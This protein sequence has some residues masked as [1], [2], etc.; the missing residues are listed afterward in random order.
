MQ[1]MFEK[2]LKSYLHTAYEVLLLSNRLEVLDPA[3][4]L[5]YDSPLG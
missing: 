1:G 5:P 4:Q 2:P 3:S